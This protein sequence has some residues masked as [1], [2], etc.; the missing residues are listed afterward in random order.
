[1]MSYLLNKRSDSKHN[2]SARNKASMKFSAVYAQNFNFGKPFQLPTVISNWTLEGSNSNVPLC[3][4]SHIKGSQVGKWLPKIWIRHSWGRHWAF[5]SSFSLYSKCYWLNHQKSLWSSNLAGRSRFLLLSWVMTSRISGLNFLSSE[6]VLWLL[7]AT[8][9]GGALVTPDSC[10]LKQNRAVLCAWEN[11][12]EVSLSGVTPTS[13]ATSTVLS[14]WEK[15]ATINPCPLQSFLGLFGQSSDKGMT[16]FG[17]HN[18]WGLK[19]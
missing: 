2:L 6:D 5:G 11:R 18:N 13:V 1:M 15:G 19:S 14:T 3:T 7:A 10:V 4:L 17:E 9:K 12:R 8:L 16:L